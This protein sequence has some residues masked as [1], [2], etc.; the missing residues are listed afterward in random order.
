MYDRF[1]PTEPDRERKAQL[2]PIP[3]RPLRKHGRNGHHPSS[4]PSLDSPPPPPSVMFEYSSLGDGH[5][6]VVLSPSYRQDQLT[7][8]SKHPPDPCVDHD[9]NAL[10]GHSNMHDMTFSARARDV[11]ATRAMSIT[12]SRHIEL[13]VLVSSKQAQS[14]AVPRND[15]DRRLLKCSGFTHSDS[16]LARIFPKSNSPAPQGP[17]ASGGRNRMV[18]HASSQTTHSHL[19]RTLLERASR[20]P[21]GPQKQY[22]PRRGLPRPPIVLPAP[23][24]PTHHSEV[25]APRRVS[26]LLL[27][28]S[29]SRHY[30]REPQSAYRHNTLI[31]SLKVFANPASAR[32]GSLNRVQSESP[33]SLTAHR[34]SDEVGCTSPREPQTRMVAPNIDLATTQAVIPI[35]TGATQTYLSPQPLTTE[36]I[37]IAPD[38]EMRPKL[39]SQPTS[40]TEVRPI[41]RISS[42]SSPSSTRQLRHTHGNVGEARKVGHDITTN[43]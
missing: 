38:R 16:L 4:V 2:S 5:S 12:H 7:T 27:S 25:E 39:P 17:T 24:S 1:A 43:S 14:S 11:R 21:R 29:V 34:H 9:P 20:Q 32:L 35:G 36:N 18:D 37:G 41:S 10:T 33:V 13:P 40:P 28:P 6:S 23:L 42:P 30:R 19:P 8:T 15:H 31:Q 3:Q 22:C 26:E